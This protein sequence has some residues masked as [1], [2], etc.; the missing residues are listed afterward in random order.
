MENFPVPEEF[1]SFR[2]TEWQYG[3]PNKF[4]GESL[5]C[6]GYFLILSQLAGF[7]TATC[8][9]VLIKFSDVNSASIREGITLEGLAGSVGF[10]SVRWFGEVN[11]RMALVTDTYGLSIERIFEQSNRCLNL[12]SVAFIAEQLVSQIECL[13]CRGITFGNLSPSILAVGDAAWQRPQIILTDLGSVNYASNG[14]QEDLISVGRVL[15]YL[16][17]TPDSWDIFKKKRLSEQ[18]ARS[19]PELAT[20]M[21]LTS[22]NPYIDYNRL[23]GIFLGLYQDVESQQRLAGKGVPCISSFLFSG[24]VNSG[25]PTKSIFNHLRRYKLY[26]GSLVQTT[27][28]HLSEKTGSILLIAL[29][30]VLTLYLELSV[31]SCPSHSSPAASPSPYDLPNCLWRDLRWFLSLS[32]TYVKGFQEAIFSNIYKFLTVL[33]SCVPGH[34][35][36]WTE[37]LLEMAHSKEKLLISE[38]NIMD[39]K[40]QAWMQQRSYWS[41]KLTHFRKEDH[42]P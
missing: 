20:Y 16:C 36:Y 2:V 14:F 27:G 41:A 39:I 25:L 34:R 17:G 26:V 31:R 13:H 30:H 15:A 42:L 5:C 1:A 37:Y 35:I 3:A 6:F 7:H 33:M 4:F 24:M 18:L 9:N 21:E 40:L 22:C 38:K 28:Q 10:P 8:E 11:G 19:P 32:Q 12:Q 29:S 23:R